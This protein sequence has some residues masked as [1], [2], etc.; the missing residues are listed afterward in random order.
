MVGYWVRHS[1]T[2]A[3][4]PVPDAGCGA[5]LHAGNSRCCEV[6]FEVSLMSSQSIG[7]VILQLLVTHKLQSLVKFHQLLVTHKPETLT[8]FPFQDKDPNADPATWYYR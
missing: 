8:C 4:N 1:T 7:G 3:I 2:I 5:R 6:M